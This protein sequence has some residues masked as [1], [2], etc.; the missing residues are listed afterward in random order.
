MCSIGRDTVDP[1]M[2]F[3]IRLCV[4]F[5]AIGDAF[6]ENKLIEFQPGVWAANDASLLPLPVRGYQAYL[7]GEMHGVQEN[8]T[9]FRAYL[10]VLLPSG[11]RDVALEEDS[12][13]ARRAG[14]CDRQNK[15]VA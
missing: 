15:Q 13:R 4:V 2:S 14:L 10:E 5:L 9:A 7:I 11:V 8:V 1:K 6:G 12:V 3:R